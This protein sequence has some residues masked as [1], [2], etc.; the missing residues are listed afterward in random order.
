[1]LAR[2]GMGMLRGSSYA[3]VRTWQYPLEWLSFTTWVR[4]IIKDKFYVVDVYGYLAVEFGGIYAFWRALSLPKRIN[5]KRDSNRPGGFSTQGLV[6][7]RLLI[8][9]YL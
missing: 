7:I 3:G 9:S 8:L 6:L 5:Q 2:F 1:M 4:S